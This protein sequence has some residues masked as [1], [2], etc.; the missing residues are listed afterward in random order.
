VA[1]GVEAQGRERSMSEIGKEPDAALE[2]RIERYATTLALLPIPLWFVVTA[3]LAAAPAWRAEYRANPDFS[4]AGALATERELQRYWDRQNDDVPGALQAPSFFA[5]WD[6]CLSLD[7][8]RDIPFMLVTD[9]SASFSIDG[10]AR[11]SA[12]SGGLRATRGEV[13][14]L[15]A[16]THA[17]NVVLH[18]RGWP[19]IALLA[20]FDDGPPK[21]LGSGR[22]A[23]GV[24]S[25]APA[26]GAACPTP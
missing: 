10:S 3:A 23:S 9:G 17:L 5:R 19:S 16:G 4:G 6:T 7:E 26:P 21:P 14:R 2:R 20:S 1:S 22:L 13:V 25:F 11:L 15:D 18:P 24:R 12:T 8:A